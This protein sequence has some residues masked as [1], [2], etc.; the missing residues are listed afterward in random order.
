MKLNLQLITLG[1]LF[2]ILTINGCSST[3]VSE[4]THEK[5][6][7][8][9]VTYFED[10]AD[11]P[12][13]TIP[14][15]WIGGSSFAVQK[16][17]GRKMLVQT[18]SKKYLQHGFVIPDIV[19]PKNFKITFV[20]KGMPDKTA[21]PLVFTLGHNLTL[22]INKFKT[23]DKLAVKG[24][25][26]DSEFNVYSPKPY[27]FDAFKTLVIEKNGEIYNLYLDGSIIAT[28]R[29]NHTDAINTLGIRFAQGISQLSPPLVFKQIAV[30]CL[31]GKE[32]PDGNPEFTEIFHEDFSTTEIGQKPSYFIDGNNFAVKKSGLYP[33][34]YTFSPLNNKLEQTFIIPDIRF[35]KD[36][37][38]DIVCKFLKDC[39]SGVRFDIG[40]L[41]LILHT[42]G[43]S[44]FGKTKFMVD[45]ENNGS[46]P[47][48]GLSLI[49]LSDAM[50]VT[51]IRKGENFTLYINGLE[52]A[53]TRVPNFADVSNIEFHNDKTINLYIEL[54]FAFYDIK[55]TEFYEFYFADYKAEIKT[56]VENKINT[57]QERGKYEAMQDYTMRVNDITRKTQ[58]DRFTREAI[59][60]FASENLNWQSLTS[61]YDPDNEMFKLSTA[62][63]EPFYLNVPIHE[64]EEF[65]H[66]LDS[67]TLVD[68]AYTMFGNSF[69]FLNA[70]LNN[71][72]TQ[73]TYFYNAEDNISFVSSTIDYN[74]DPV[75]IPE[76]YLRDQGNRETQTKHFI[77][78][79]DVDENIPVTGLTKQ[80]IYA[81]IIGNEDYSTFQAGL[82]KE[83]NVDFAEH[84]AKIFKEYCVKTLGVPEQ[85]TRMLI[86]ATAG[87]MN[88]AIAWLKRLI[89]IEEGKAEVI[90]YY[91]GHGFPEEKTREPYLIPV[92][93]SG[94]NPEQGIALK[95]LY[96][97]LNQFSSKRTLIFLDACFSGGGRN[98][99]LVA[100]KG[101]K[102]KPQENTI[103][104]NMIVFSSSSG[105]ESS[106][107]YTEKN[108]GYFTYY[109]LKIINESKGDVNLKELSQYIITNVKKQT[110]LTGKIQTPQVLVSPLIYD[111]WESW[112]IK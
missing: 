41:P 83:S 47:R 2:S 44:T 28:R 20:L 40:N 49:G 66:H 23:N 63:F 90:F 59:Q 67:L 21:S 107:I 32:I 110:A 85:Q 86:N 25:F 56:F 18:K 14:K 6:P 95:K 45:V 58:I 111:E 27:S 31:D 48:F 76:N 77:G 98:E 7:N 73:K 35:P 109:L 100:L 38:L 37:K 68:A 70:T 22:S 79:S 75:T 87:Q 78:K 101:V 80:N 88:Q 64:A 43:N 5:A 61:E 71:P 62:G 29:G 74:F 4:A 42:N 53:K 106:G 112:K 65:D 97:D 55:L 39:C 9:C 108:H 17:S 69:G 57:W 81:L 82:R 94:Y 50:L 60:K 89:E 54:G 104:G 103:M 72:V 13:G 16:S 11:I 84:D 12:E 99:G 36:F 24:Y 8:H 26:G 19:F 51:I 46:K 33:D 30:E 93:I 3:K 34:K 1:F 96:E 105:N 92:D 91:S 15:T 102:V 10:F 52:V